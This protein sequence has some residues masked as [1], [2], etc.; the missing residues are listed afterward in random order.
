MDTPWIVGF[1]PR[2]AILAL[3]FIPQPFLTRLNPTY[4][5]TAPQLSRYVSITAPV[6]S[7]GASTQHAYAIWD[8][9]TVCDYT[10]NY[11]R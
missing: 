2:P 5:I 1:R 9:P 6:K 3:I 8:A 4:K 10:L 11:R 7:T